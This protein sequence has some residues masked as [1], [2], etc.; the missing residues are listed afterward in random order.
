MV[1]QSSPGSGKALKGIIAGM[2]FCLGLVSVPHHTSVL[3]QE[4]SQVES[5]FASH[6]Q[7]S[8]SKLSSNW[9]NGQLSRDTQVLVML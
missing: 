6:F 2:F 3:L 9:T 7:L 1:Q 8:M 4:A 5:K